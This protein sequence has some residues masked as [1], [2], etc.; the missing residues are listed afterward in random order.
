MSRTVQKVDIVGIAPSLF[1][2][3]HVR[4]MLQLTYRD[5]LGQNQKAS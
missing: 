4:M 1:L 2:F 5:F 3:L